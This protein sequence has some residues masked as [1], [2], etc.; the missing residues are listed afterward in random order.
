MRPKSASVQA[1]RGSLSL[2]RNGRARAFFPRRTIG[3][4]LAMSVSFFACAALVES[5]PAAT[6]SLRP[7]ADAYVKASTPRTNY[8]ATK[9]L[10][11]DARPVMRTYIRFQLGL[12]NASVVRA[13]L[14]LYTRSRSAHGFAVRAIRRNRWR[15]RG[16]TF[17]TAPPPRATIASSGG[18]RARVW[19]G[20][21]VTRFVRG[22]R[23]VSFAVTTRARLGTL[24]LA[25]RESRFSPRL[26]IE[27]QA[28]SGSADIQGTV[29][30][31]GNIAGCR[32]NGDEATAAL[33]AGMP[34]GRVATLGNHAYPAGT[35]AEFANCYRPS[36]GR[37]VERTSP[38]LGMREYDTPGAAG[39]VGFFGG[40]LASYGP[41][42]ADPTRGYYSYELGSWHV[43]VL[44]TKCRLAG[45]TPGSPQFEWLRA[46]LAAH[47]TSC[48]L[49]YGHRARFSS[50][51][52]EN[53]FLDPIWRLLYENGVEVALAGHGREY[54]RFAPQSASGAPDPARGIRQFVVG[55]GGIGARSTGM[56]IGNSDIRS[57]DTLGVLELRLRTTG[58]EWR[59]VPVA[60]KSFSDTGSASCH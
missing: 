12:L 41:T 15:E 59:F 48:T 54:E 14:R 11:V 7:V 44:N 42:A 30:A 58:Y 33:V 5:A 29:I 60:G 16:I 21:D 31:A 35:P 18:V 46:D 20:V 13:R 10:G 50:R 56:P 51:D 19:T 55:T 40:V 52:P 6:R 26:E 37:F 25:S 49:A 17:R 57:G 39:Y 43:V 36:W 34:G 8:G 28:G 3:P 38:A 23:V 27:T 1:D 32:T 47:P 24:L 53:V 2:A 4:V 45:C 22:K 9:A